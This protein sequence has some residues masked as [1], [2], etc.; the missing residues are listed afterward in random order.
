MWEAERATVNSQLGN[1]VK[2]ESSKWK[3][4]TY[5]AGYETIIGSLA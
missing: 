3:Y 4:K 5:S 1:A 2:M